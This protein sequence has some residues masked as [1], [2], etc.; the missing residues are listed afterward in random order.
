VTTPSGTSPGAGGA[1]SAGR[2]YPARPIVGVGGVVFIGGRVLLIKRRFEPL[3]G[4][5]SLPGG[6]LEVGETMAEGLAREMREE[7]GLEV[8]VGPVVEVFDRIT[9]DEHGRARYHYVLVDFLCTACG[10]HPAA[11]SDVAEVALANPD[12]LAGFDLTPKTL[13]V[14]ARARSLAG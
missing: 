12:D 10:G 6:A 5:W 4:R 3:A 9:R 1:P 7:T 13:E 8:T 11:G 14:I 2:E